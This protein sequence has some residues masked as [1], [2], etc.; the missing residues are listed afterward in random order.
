LAKR[1]EKYLRAVAALPCVH[2]GLEGSS[3]A[4][5]ANTGKAMGKKLVSDF[6]TFPLCADRP[7]VRGCHSRFDQ[8]ALFTKYERREI[9]QRWISWTRQAL[10]IDEGI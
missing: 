10:C 9:E 4:A 8:G 3:Q 7:G 2:C 1:H 6:D 5:H